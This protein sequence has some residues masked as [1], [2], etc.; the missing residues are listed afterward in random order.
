ML[1]MEK[2]ME[3]LGAAGEESKHDV[4]PQLSASQARWMANT[5]HPRQIA[6][7]LQHSNSSNSN[8]SYQHPIP[9]AR[10]NNAANA[11]MP[12]SN[13]PPPSSQYSSSAFSARINNL[14]LSSSSSPAVPSSSSSALSPVLNSTHSHVPLI[15]HGS[16]SRH[17]SP[18]RGVDGLPASNSPHLTFMAGASTH[19]QQHNSPARRIGYAAAQS[20]DHREREYTQRIAAAQSV[21]AAP[22]PAKQQPVPLNFGAS[23]THQPMHSI[24]S[25]SS[26]SSSSVF[27]SSNS[28]HPISGS[29]ALSQDSVIPSTDDFIGQLK[30]RLKQTEELIHTAKMTQKMGE[31]MQYQ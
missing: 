12:A 15:V 6:Q 14:A 16:G 11:E 4:A 5:Q 8:G 27:P 17:N 7:A 9:S 21:D 30:M 3:H 29:A 19:K 2:K 28:L 31:N 22:S 24:F 25:S 10:N 23:T 13:V 26:S 20:R 1:L 18:L